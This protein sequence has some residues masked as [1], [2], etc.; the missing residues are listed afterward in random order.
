[1][2]GASTFTSTPTVVSNPVCAQ[3]PTPV[4]L[5]STTSYH[6]TIGSSGC[7]GVT[8]SVQFA[9]TIAVT[10]SGQLCQSF[11]MVA[12]VPPDHRLCQRDPARPRLASVARAR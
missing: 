3:T 11:Y 10:A 7:P 8:W 4:V 1:M 5:S 12:A 6:A 9:E 2:T